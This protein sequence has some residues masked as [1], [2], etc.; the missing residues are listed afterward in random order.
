M[1]KINELVLSLQNTPI[2][3]ELLHVFLDFMLRLA[4]LIQF[5]DN[6]NT[7]KLS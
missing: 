2:V 5:K 1:N 4:Y 7:D 6:T 3:Y